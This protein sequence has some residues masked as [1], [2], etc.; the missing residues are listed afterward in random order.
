M[1]WFRRTEARLFILWL[2]FRYACL[3]N[4]NWKH[5]AAKIHMHFLEGTFKEAWAPLQDGTDGTRPTQYFLLFNTTLMGVAWKESTPEGLRPPQY[6]EG[7]G[8]LAR[9][10]SFFDF[11]VSHTRWK[12]HPD[13]IMFMQFTIHG[14][15]TWHHFG[16]AKCSRSWDILEKKHTYIHAYIHTYIQTNMTWVRF[17]SLV[18]LRLRA[19]GARPPSE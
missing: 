13:A 9:K 2:F 19:F 11:H 8:A 16:F 18:W 10:Q 4:S 5:A 14:A 6:S 15:T 12:P 3:P 1:A 17:P 7:G